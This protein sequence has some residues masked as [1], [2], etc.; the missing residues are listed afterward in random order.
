MAA[1]NRVAVPD[2][3]A[4][5]VRVVAQDRVEAQNR[6]GWIGCRRWIYERVFAS[7]GHGRR[8]EAATWAPGT[9]LVVILN[10]ETGFRFSA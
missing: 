6:V 2:R 8:G 4:A 3:V 1:Q 10:V 5:Q 9:V 7:G